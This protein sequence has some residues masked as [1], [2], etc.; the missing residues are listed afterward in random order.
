MFHRCEYLKVFGSSYH[1][2][3]LLAKDIHSKVG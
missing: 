3:T 1:K 2:V